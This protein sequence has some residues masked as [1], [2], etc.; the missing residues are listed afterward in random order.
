MHNDIAWYYVIP[1]YDMTRNTVSSY[2]MVYHV[3]VCHGVAWHVVSNENDGVI[4]GS[5]H[6]RY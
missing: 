3:M 6:N 5:N 2:A 1:S 4:D